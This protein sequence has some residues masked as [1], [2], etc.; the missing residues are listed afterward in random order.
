[1]LE[2]MNKI[3]QVRWVDLKHV[4][5]RKKEKIEEKGWYDNMVYIKHVEE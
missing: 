5:T 1:M 4:M 2:I 3:A